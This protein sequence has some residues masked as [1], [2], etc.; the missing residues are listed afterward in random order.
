[1]AANSKS[2]KKSTKGKKHSPDAE[3]A[4][5]QDAIKSLRSTVAK[6]EKNVVKL[7]AKL[8]KRMSELRSDAKKFRTAAERAGRSAVKSAQGAGKSAAKSA[9]TSAGKVSD[10]KP[11][12][13]E[14]VEV[15]PVEEAPK[16][17]MTVAQL[18]TAARAQGVAGYSRMAKAQLV[19]AL[20]R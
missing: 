2:G 12:P 14:K 16:S 1:M 6:L 15:V 17:E 4:A 10:Q 9:K 7:E 3:L 20:K 19:A 5:A 13:A 18:R 8:E 11:A